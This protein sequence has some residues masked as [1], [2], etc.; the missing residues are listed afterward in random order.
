MFTEDLAPFFSTDAFGIAA[1]LTLGGTPATV[2]VIF[3]SAYFDPLGQFEGSTPM[4]WLPSADAIGVAHG[5]TLTLGGTVY[6]IVEVMPDGSG[7]VVQ[8]RM[9]R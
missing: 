6:T 5:D 3:D 9:R 2:N 4:A 8:L 1:T 7:N